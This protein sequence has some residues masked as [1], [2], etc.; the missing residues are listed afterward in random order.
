MPAYREVKRQLNRHRTE[1]CIPIPDTRE[2]PEMLQ[3]T[4]RAREADDGDALK[5]ERFL[6]YTGQNGK[7]VQKSFFYT[8]A[9]PVGL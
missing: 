6:Q 2:I 8:S 3:V 4:L 1:R 9:L 5:T 7:R